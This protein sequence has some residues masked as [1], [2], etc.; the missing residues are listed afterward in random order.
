MDKDNI[1]IAC[2][3]CGTRNR[4]PLKKIRQKPVCAK[5]KASLADIPW[6]PVNINDGDFNRVV[7]KHRGVVLVDCWA[8]W[9]GPCRS[10]GPVLDQLARSYAGR[11]L[12]AK[13]NMDDN[14]KTGARYDIRSIPTL[15]LFKD[16]VRKDSLAGAVPRVEIEK[17]ITP[18]L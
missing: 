5:C 16:G 1:I 2:R 3:S 9:C 12:V 7:K 6:F 14:P 11:V 18:L 10:M 13:I 17:R 15:L 8:P 4:V